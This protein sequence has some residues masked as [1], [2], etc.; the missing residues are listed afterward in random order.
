MDFVETLNK[1][2]PTIKFTAEW[3]QKSINFLDVSVSLIE[4]QSKSNYMSSLQIAK[5][6]FILPRVT[7]IIVRKAFLMVKYYPLT[8]FVWGFFDIICNNSEKWLNEI[9]CS[10]KLVRKEILKAK[11]Q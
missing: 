3:S 1:I 10:E 6:T 2:H 11:S 9:G 8:E 5:N 4:S 7:H